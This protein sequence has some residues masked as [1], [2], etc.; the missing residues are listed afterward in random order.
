MSGASAAS[1]FDAHRSKQKV[2]DASVSTAVASSSISSSIGLEK[3]V[4]AGKRT[5]TPDTPGRR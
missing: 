5:K 2:L 4:N 3:S 1:T